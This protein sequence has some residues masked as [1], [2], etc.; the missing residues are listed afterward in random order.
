MKPFRL[1]LPL[2]LLASLSRPTSALELRNIPEPL[3]PWIPWVLADQPQADCPFLLRDFQQKRCSWPGLVKL[4]IEAER[5]EFSGEWTLYQTD[6]VILPGDRELWPQQV[7]INRLPAVVTVRQGKPAIRLDAGRY[8]INGQFF[9]RRPPESL[10]LASDIGLVQASVNGI[11][12]ANPH[13][14]QDRLWLNS[15]NETGQ[16]TR[17][18]AVN[19]Q[20]FRRIL[21][22]NP[23]QLANRLVLDISGQAREINLDHALLPGFIPISLHSPLPARIDPNGRLQLQARP[24]HWQV[25]LNARHPQN[26]AQ[27]AFSVQDE[28]WPTTELWAFQAVPAL[29]LVEIEGVTGIDPSQSQLPPEWR[30]L[31]TYRMQQGQ[32]IR[33]KTLRRG[34]PEPEPNQLQLNRKLW[35]DFDGGGYTVS[36]RLDGRMTRD[37]RLNTTPNLRLGQVLLDGQAQ[38][39][40]QQPNG[41]QGI[42]IR[43]GTLHMQADS[44]I[45]PN[46]GH[47][48]A[49]GW[50]QTFRQVQAELNIPPGWRLL[51]VSGTDNSPSC[52]LN[53]WTLLDL[54][55]LLLIA[56]AA[57]R[58]WSW[59]WGLLIGIGLLSF[60]HETDAPRWIWLHLL[61]V[62][63]LLRIAPSGRLRLCTTA[64]RHLAWLALLLIALPFM[65]AQL[66]SGLYPQ[67]ANPL[68]PIEPIAFNASLAQ[69]DEEA[70]AGAIMEMTPRPAPQPLRKS[71]AKAGGDSAPT[72]ATLQDPDANLQT[73]PGLPQWQWHSVML[74][75]NGAVDGSQRIRFWYMGPKTSLV[76]HFAQVLLLAAMLLKMLD[77]PLPSWRF[78]RPAANLCWLMVLLLLPIKNSPADIPDPAMLEQLKNRL[79]QAP[80]CLPACADI[81]GMKLT[82]TPDDMRIELQIHAQQAIAVPLPGQTGQWLPESVT[83][84]GRGGQSVLKQAD[85]HLWLALER[86]VH[87]VV[88]AGRH[89]DAVKFTLPLPLKPRYSELTV[90]GWQVEGLYDN[91]K[92]AAQLEFNRINTVAHPARNRLESDTLAPFVRL[93]RTL[94]FG[95]DW[96]ISNRLVRL[97]D[98]GSPIVLRIPLLAGESVTSDRIPIEGGH[99]MVNMPAGQSNLAWE[100][101]L[102][103]HPRQKLTAADTSDWSELWRAEVSPIWHLQST[104]LPPISA[105]GA[106]TAWQPEW[107]PWP[108]E[109][110]QLDISRPQAIAGATAT[111]DDSRFSLNPGQRYQLAELNLTLRSSKAGQHPLKLPADVE[112]Q[113]VS[114]DGVDHPIRLQQG[115]ASIPIRPGSQQIRLTWRRAAEQPTWFTTPE[116]DLGMPSAN[117]NLQVTLNENRWVLLTFGPSFGP[118][119]LIWSLIALLGGLAWGLG[120]LGYTPLNAWQWF[121][122]LLGLSQIPLAASFIV[123]LWFAAL[124]LRD[125]D[126]PA[127]AWQ[128][129]LQQAGLAVLTLL[130]GAVL[131]WVVRH[132][133]LGAPDMQIAGNQSRAWQLNWYQ[134]R[135][136]SPTLPQ[137]SVLSLPIVCY[138]L[139]MLAWSLWLAKSLPGWLSWGWQRFAA[140]LPGKKTTAQ[141]PD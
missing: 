139:L 59:P 21:D 53:D 54:C 130:A 5:G 50:Q 31:P 60:W 80:A 67:L 120:K 79:L 18:D 14:E 108:G 58:L 104:G 77:R 15:A 101:V 10:P 41:D 121:W 122:L 55:L 57:G 86:G 87:Q 124:S 36:D 127:A 118:A 70:A 44:R 27:L 112:L 56:L 48:D 42:E 128:L 25:D 63:A 98:N 81:A 35:L 90:D 82:G 113:T 38:L 16:T 6:W 117:A 28:N 115:V 107:R 84:D 106:Q 9:W 134:D 89:G 132:G 40:T 111:I 92:T 7:T 116:I 109:S 110:L 51:A 68:Q 46:I 100:S 66:R 3:K 13:I 135:I 62:H 8:Q 129:N 20:V 96:R 133:L 78:N 141:A 49:V 88:L 61:A 76:L 12:L 119:V 1:F 29:R 45:E 64:Y 140:G 136:D 103:Q 39:I 47:I 32:T 123:A 75:W 17:P 93:E 95:L 22:D 26:L 138:R 97:A 4:T 11:P 99:V 74:S 30:Q 102:E 23:L 83:V 34:D 73:G 114:I 131:F 72:N 2:L 33:F 126:T 71:M 91:G 24:G 19:L 137:A 37:W 85:G 69:S 43:R 105:A 52:W 125:R 94:Q 65:A